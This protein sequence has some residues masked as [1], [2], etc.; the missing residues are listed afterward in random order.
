MLSTVC[1][2]S[3]WTVLNKSLL[4]LRPPGTIRNEVQ[5]LLFPHVD[6]DLRA[7][8][9][10]LRGL[11]KNGSEPSVVIS[12]THID[13]DCISIE[14]GGTL[15]RLCRYILV[16]IIRLIEALPPRREEGLEPVEYRGQMSETAGASKPHAA[17]FA[18]S[19]KDARSDGSPRFDVAFTSSTTNQ[20]LSE[21]NVAMGQNR[22]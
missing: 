21:P 13:I 18:I 19:A 8:L 7:I 15:H 16:E 10:T 12:H 20:R 9:T 3:R 1:V 6:I 2:G 14:L 5:L 4:I 17:A 11:P 22:S